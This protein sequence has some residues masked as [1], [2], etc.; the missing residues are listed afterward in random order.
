MPRYVLKNDNKLSQNGGLS[1]YNN[2]PIIFSPQPPISFQ[3]L[4]PQVQVSS[5]NSAPLIPNSPFGLG[6]VNSPFGL[7][8]V[9]SP[10]GLSSVNNAPLIPNNPFG[11][12]AAPQSFITSAP[13]QFPLLNVPVPLLSDSPTSLNIHT[14]QG[15]VQITGTESQFRN[16][17]KRAEQLN[18]SAGKEE[19]QTYKPVT[20]EMLTD[21]P[22]NEQDN[23]FV[24]DQ[25]K[26]VDMGW[27]LISLGMRGVQ[28]TQGGPL[29]NSRP[30]ISYRTKTDLKYYSGAGLL[31]FERN[32]NSVG[33]NGHTV[34][35]FSSK[36]VYQDFGGMI[37]SNDF[38]SSNSLQLTAKRETLEESANYIDI[39]FNLDRLIGNVPMY[40]DVPHNTTN[41]RCYA[42][43]LDE[44][45][46]NIG[47][48]VGNVDKIQKTPYLPDA[49][50]E[51][52]GAQRFYLSD[53]V[54]CIGS[55]NGANVKCKDI[56]GT[57]HQIRART[58]ECLKK[59]LA[60]YGTGKSIAERAIGYVNLAREYSN[61]LG[62]RKLMIY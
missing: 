40:V 31:I 43:G 56:N 60:S 21:P 1:S 58:V 57:E 37:D 27:N 52:N 5:V 62:M 20:R 32:Y 42:I 35:L 3:P 39:Q 6:S 46:F 30:G 55:I 26:S 49:W 61:A 54:K 23:Y 8:N 17:L 29:G 59:M 19:N 15:N 10:F 14:P 33:K 13:R 48:F 45:A 53:L 7:G 25:N 18:K 16:L 4:V 9:N 28:G 51:I 22:A 12:N 34:L 11:L 47:S 24:P 50:K 44:D 36:G 38:R 41:Y 2:G